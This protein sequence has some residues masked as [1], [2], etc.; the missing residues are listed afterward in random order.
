MI[1]FVMVL[2]LIHS[3]KIGDGFANIPDIGVPQAYG[4]QMECVEAAHVL[5]PLVVSAKF[6]AVMTQVGVER[7]ALVCV[8]IDSGEAPV[9]ST[10]PKVAPKG[11]PLKGTPLPGSIEASEQPS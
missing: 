7:Y 8:G 1:H 6:K 10:K 9:L 3:P 5:V 11:P 2:L 4:T